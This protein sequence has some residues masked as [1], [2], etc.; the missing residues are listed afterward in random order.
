[1]T[2]PTPSNSDAERLADAAGALCDL[3]G[4]LYVGDELI[5]GA[6]E[7]IDFLRERGMR[8]RFL[9]NTTTRSRRSLHLHVRSLGL[10]IDESE[11][12]SAAY[13]G[14][15]YL[16]SV[17]S[18]RCRLIL[19]EDAASDYAEFPIDENDPQVIVL[20]DIGR[21]WD[22]DLLD[23]IFRQVAA[24]ARLAA[25]HRNRYFQTANGLSLDVGA[26]VAALEYAT[27][28]EAA[29]IG[30]PAADFFNLA[31]GDLELPPGKV[32]I[33][34][35]D[36]D[37]D[38]GAGQDSGLTGILVKTGKYRERMAAAS[39]VTPMFT[40]DSVEMLTSLLRNSR[41]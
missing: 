10:S 25:L 4:T 2:R 35:D 22:Y 20:G 30:K 13:A 32:I 5:P 18:P 38:V 21:R 7:A 16:R 17:G 41:T 3:D 11:I 1:M 27:R 31:L 40:L 19:A 39:A 15:L 28:T 29:V 12:L 33:I 24:G 14:V 23:S 37:N 6:V 34:G 8:L 36:I 9:T 26:F